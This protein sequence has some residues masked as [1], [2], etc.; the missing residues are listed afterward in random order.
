[1]NKERGIAAVEYVAT[2][3]RKTLEDEFRTPVGGVEVACEWAGEDFN[4]VVLT[5]PAGKLF[6]IVTSVV[7]E[8]GADV[9][10]AVFG[11]EVFEF[12]AFPSEVQV[13][14]LERV[15][16]AVAAIPEVDSVWPDAEWSKT[17]LVSV[18]PEEVDS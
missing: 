12:G 15:A 17:F 6:I 8:E 7:G 4:R 14:E 13:R 1:M 18:R 11:P 10:V 3:L 16:R 5:T 2:G 9:R